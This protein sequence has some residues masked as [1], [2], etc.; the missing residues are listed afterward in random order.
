MLVNEKK[1]GKTGWSESETNR[2]F[3]LAAE[4][5]KSTRSLKSVFDEVASLTGRRPNS[6]RNY[7]YARVKEDGGVSFS[8]RRA[9]VPFTDEESVNLLEEVLR[10]Q[11][12]GESVRACT[13]RLANGDDKVMLRYQNKYRALLK[14]DPALVRRIV[15]DLKKCGT[16]A[17]D[18][19]S[20]RE[21]A[22]RVG[23]PPKRVTE[24]DSFARRVL[25][26][27]SRVPGLD[28]RALLDSLGTLAVAAVRGTESL[29]VHGAMPEIE[30]SAL[31]RQLDVQRAQL[32]RQSERYRMLLSS[33]AQL[34]RINSEFLSLNSVVKVSN[35]SSYIRDLETN[36]RSCEQLMHD[37]A[38]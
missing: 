33:F 13:L 19:F 32:Q 14:N 1:P 38:H 4:A 10:A 21:S 30:V 27:L 25:A 2:L 26:D 36:V 17:F 18:P 3:A 29:R 24:S 12:R 22:P 8:H 16:P 11:G 9:F 34:I 31:Q 28:T 7:Y 37:G 23:R 35:L 6:V 5:Q 15:I 20:D